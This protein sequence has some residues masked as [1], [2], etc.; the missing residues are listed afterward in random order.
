[1][2]PDI[3]DPLLDAPFWLRPRPDPISGDLRL[4]WG[5]ALIVLMIG[6][7]RG[8]RASFP[9]L[10]LLAHSAR[11]MHGRQAMVRYLETRATSDQPLIRFEPWLNR[12]LSFANAER[13]TS[14]VNGKSA[15]LTA[16]GNAMLSALGKADGLMREE[17]V[18]A[19]RCARALSEGD[20]QNFLK[21]GR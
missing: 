2:L 16:S 3:R 5:L 15:T 9:K 21:R 19:E 11:T 20:I 10:H 17:R 4:S 13:L 6:N 18:F 1:M 7:S 12:A 14:F 8:K